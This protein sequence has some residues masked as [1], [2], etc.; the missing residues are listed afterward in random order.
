MTPYAV[1]KRDL[2]WGRIRRRMLW[3]IMG[4]AELTE[5]RVL[6]PSIRKAFTDRV[7]CGAIRPV[8]VALRTF[9]ARIP[10]MSAADYLRYCRICYDAAFPAHRADTPEMSYRAFADGR[11]GGLFGLRRNSRRAFAEWFSSGRFTGTHP[12]EIVRDSI[13]LT[14]HSAENGGYWLRLSC[15]RRE[16]IS[17]HLILMA[18][19]LSRAGVPFGLQNIDEHAL[20]A[21]GDDWIG[22]ADD[23]VWERGSPLWPSDSGILNAPQ[24]SFLVSELA[25]YPAALRQ[26]RWFT[27]PVTFK[28]STCAHS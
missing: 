8:E 18:V 2:R 16:E 12:F 11:S 10:W 5:L 7:T 15:R 4:A 9:T 20:F 22:V 17:P 6:S 28:A 14:V 21:K 27:S 19:G 13:T 26:V 1:P 25:V 23:A 24:N 3:P